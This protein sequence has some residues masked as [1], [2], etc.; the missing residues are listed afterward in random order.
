[1]NFN[2]EFELAKNIAHEAG[3]LA[4]KMRENLNQIVEKNPKDL[5][6]EADLACDLLIREAILKSFPTHGLVTEEGIDFNTDSPYQWHID[7]IDGTANYAAGLPL[8]GVSIAMEYEGA[9]QLGVVNCPMTNQ[10][11]TALKGHGAFCNEKRISVNSDSDLKTTMVINNGLNLGKTLAAQAEYNQKWF[12]L[13]SKLMPAVGRTRNFG[14][15]V[16]EAAAVA[17]GHASAY[18]IMGYNA[19]DIAAMV[20]IVEEAG[21][22]CSSFD[23]SPFMLRNSTKPGLLSNGIIHQKL[24]DIINS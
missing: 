11:F 2:K 12:Q 18:T 19:Y 17:L 1:M 9:L 16:Y 8:W 5:V 6:T 21:G 14:A 22:K 4:V 10:F 13:I 15:A 7:P 23:G 24:L 3:L 20:L